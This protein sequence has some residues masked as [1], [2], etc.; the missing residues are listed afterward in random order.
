MTAIETFQFP[1]TGATVRTVLRDGEPWF[2]ALDVCR[3]LGIVNPSD[4]VGGLDDDEK[5]VA[6]TD[7]PGGQQDVRII[8]EPGL[9]SLILRSR[10][11][12]AKTFK[13]WV[14]HDVLPAIRQTGRY[15]VAPA[16]PQSYADALR[17]LAAQ[18]E[19]T[20]RVKA[21]LE[22]AAPKAD[23]WDTLASGRGDYSVGDAAKILSRDPAITIGERRLFA[24]LHDLRWI[25]RAGDGR[26]RARQT[27]VDAG[28]LAELAQ[29]KTDESSGDTIVYP[30]QVRVTVKG[31]YELHRRLGGLQPLRVEQP[32]LTVVHSTDSPAGPPVDTPV[33]LPG[34]PGLTA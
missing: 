9:Y 26:W 23:A 29:S 12:E 2:V 32:L 25:Y 13:R 24:K 16:L 34:R 11:P 17:E 6:T 8:N 19:E 4:A 14:T 20:E 3:A 33:S 31:L 21:E 18:V 1:A 15:E 28:R 27:Q 5:G 10:R 30:P 7:T 22:T